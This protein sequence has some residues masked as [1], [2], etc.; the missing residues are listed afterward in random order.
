[1]HTF[2]LTTVVTV[3]FLL[4]CPIFSHLYTR[5][6]HNMTYYYYG[7]DLDLIIDYG[8]DLDLIIDSSAHTFEVIILIHVLNTA[9]YDM[10]S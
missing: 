2:I 4:H 3:L 9:V 7:T 6:A 10:S 1:M 8:T 5:T